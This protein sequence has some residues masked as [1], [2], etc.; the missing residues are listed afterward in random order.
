MSSQ[1]CSTFTTGSLRLPHY[2]EAP[3]VLL[4]QPPELPPAATGRGEA[5]V[6]FLQPPKVPSDAAGRGKAALSCPAAP[7]VPPEA[8]QCVEAA[9]HVVKP[10]K[11]PPS[12]RRQPPLIL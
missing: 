9:V 1:N 7:G 10:P 3:S 5:A 12:C 8:G 6:H 2:L 11:V 4:V